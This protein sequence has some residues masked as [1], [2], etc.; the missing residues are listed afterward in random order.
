MTC[1]HSSLRYLD[2]RLSR[3]VRVEQVG[4]M[5]LK[6]GA[7][8]RRGQLGAAGGTFTYWRGRVAGIDLVR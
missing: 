2:A 3:R 5:R 6:P 8:I 4:E 7:D 1:L